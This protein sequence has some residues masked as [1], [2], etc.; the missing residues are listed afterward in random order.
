MDATSASV[1]AHG[2]ANATGEFRVPRSGEENSGG[3]SGRG[4][5]IVYANRTI[6]HAERR[7][8]EARNRASI[9]IVDPTNQGDFFFKRQ[10]AEEN[11]NAPFNLGGCRLLLAHGPQ[12]KAEKEGDSEQEG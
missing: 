10:L 3:V 2:D 12:S 7:N 8:V 5:V 6:G 11:S 4:A 9:E 1:L